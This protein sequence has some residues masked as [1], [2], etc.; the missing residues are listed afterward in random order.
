MVYW[1]YL[2]CIYKN[3]FVFCNNITDINLINQLKLKG[4]WKSN[5]MKNVLSYVV[6]QCIWLF[7]ITSFRIRSIR[8]ML[9]IRR[10]LR[11][12]CKRCKRE[13]NKRRRKS[14]PPETSRRRG[15]SGPLGSSNAPLGRSTK[16]ICKLAGNQ[17][18]PWRRPTC[19]RRRTAE[20]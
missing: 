2:N 10:I 15:W 8:R 3:M 4:D 16:M 20:M 1:F 14:A 12:I 11:K 19:K 13:P 5:P 6:I 17:A 18:W 9:A 7:E